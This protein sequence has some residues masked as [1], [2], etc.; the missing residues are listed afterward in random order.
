MKINSKLTNEKIHFH[1]HHNNTG[2]CKFRDHCKHQHFH[3][4]C[5]KKICKSQE[6]QNRHPKT[7]KF[8]D[9]CKFNA[10]N[11]CAYKHQKLVDTEVDETKNLS[12]KIKG[13]QDEVR[14]LQAEMSKLKKCIQLKEDE[15]SQTKNTL[16]ESIAKNEELTNKV[17]IL[18]TVK[19]EEKSICKSCDFKAHRNID[20]ENHKQS[21]YEQP[22]V[23]EN[24][25][26]L[27]SN[28]VEKA[29]IL[30]KNV[31]D[32]DN[33]NIIKDEKHNELSLNHENSDI[34]TLN[35]SHTFSFKCQ[36]CG[37]IFENNFILKEH[38][39]N[40]RGPNVLHAMRLD[41]EESDWETDEE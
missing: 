3:T 29:E 39:I 40:H 25:K 35:S 10:R 16:D 8:G 34:E 18:N 13:L 22:S 5:L 26:T 28:K 41:F 37:K 2:F 14:F 24:L 31:S 30:N 20:L 33:D 21:K 6:C 38:I 1:C 32:I 9:S 4:I 19:V 27:I 36:Y 15:I 11:A 7:C 12:K 17:R 23:I